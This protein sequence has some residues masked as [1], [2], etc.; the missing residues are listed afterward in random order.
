MSRLN[1]W[2]I[3]KLLTPKD[4]EAVA[5]AKSLH[6]GDIKEDDAETDLGRQELHR[7]ILEK[8]HNEEASAGMI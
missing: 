4:K 7:I 6:Y 8:Y 1:W 2:E 3:E 5:K